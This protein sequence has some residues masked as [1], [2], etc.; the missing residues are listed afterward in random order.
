MEKL[1]TVAGEMTSGPKYEETGSGKRAWF[2]I[3][4]VTRRREGDGWVDNPPVVYHVVTQEPAAVGVVA[5]L[6][7]RARVL[8]SGVVHDEHP[9][10]IE[11]DDIAVSLNLQGNG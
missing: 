1:V 4:V 6:A 2:A 10:V 9:H 8:V 11:A 5:T 3:S 7:D